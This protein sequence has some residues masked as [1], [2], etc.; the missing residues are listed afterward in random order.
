[1]RALILALFI[2]T[3]VANAPIAHAGLSTSPRGATAPAET[4][5]VGEDANQQSEN[6]IGL[7]KAKRRAVQRGL[8]RL[9]F[10]TKADGTFDEQ[11][12]AAI[13]RWQEERGYPTTGFL[14]A[15]QHKAL[16]TAAAE[17]ARSDRQARRQS[18][19]RTRHSRNAGGPIGAIGGAMHRVVGGIFGR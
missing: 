4:A 8:T 18:G 7:T 6:Q 2:L 14:N 11:T 13:S 3:I 19:G 17:A 12:R 5:S 16:I 15:A 1:M 9:G 10:D